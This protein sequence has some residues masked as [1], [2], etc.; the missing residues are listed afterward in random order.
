VDAIDPGGSENPY[1]DT[2]MATQPETPRQRPRK[3]AL[4]ENSPNTPTPSAH[5]L[6]ITDGK[7]PMDT[8][9][10]MDMMYRLMDEVRD[11]LD[12]LDTLD[13]LDTL[14]E[15]NAWYKKKPEEKTKKKTKTKGN[16]KP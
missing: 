9:L 4:V 13:T 6:R 2:E 5:I 14:E 10:V 15:Q 11:M 1:E 7:T 16:L 12:M 8:E 3:R